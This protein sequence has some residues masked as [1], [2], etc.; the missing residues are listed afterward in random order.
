MNKTNILH[1]LTFA[2]PN[3]TK[4]QIPALN[5]FLLYMNFLQKSIDKMIFMWYN[6]VYLIIILVGEYMQFI[7][8]FK[9]DSNPDIISGNFNVSSV[10]ASHRHITPPNTYVRYATEH[11]NDR[12]IYIASGTIV[13]DM[14]N[15][16]PITAS[17]GCT[18]YIPHNI[19]YKANW[20][21][22]ETGELYSANFIL[23]DSNGFQSNLYPEIFLFDKCDSGIMKNMFIECFET[24]S[25]TRYAYM[26]KCKSIVY[27]ML[28]TL[29]TM[30]EASINSK[31]GKALM[32]LEHNFLSEISIKELADMCNLG[33]CMFRRYFKEETHTSPLKYRNRLRIMYAYD[34]LKSEPYSV[35]EVMEKTGFYDAS[36]FNK[37][38]KIYIGKSPSEC[39]K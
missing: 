21:E 3:L 24:F 8:K 10:S 16:N 18:V 28:Y 14:Y 27:K 11:K 31:I 2:N 30:Q 38:F 20:K 4:M 9:F 5:T 33:E 29:I 12:L 37:T 17:K 7:K 6:T 15:N 19:A 23:S 13:F 35:S 26:I 39:K 36:Y 22:D 1:N 34:L 25:Q 32:Y